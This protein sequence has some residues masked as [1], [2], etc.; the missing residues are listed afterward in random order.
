MKPLLS[1][2]ALTVVCL[3]CLLGLAGCGGGENNASGL[4]EENG[5]LGLQLSPED[6]TSGGMTLI[7]LQE[8][9]DL[10]GDWATGAA[11]TLERQEDGRWQAVEPLL[12]EGTYGWDYV[13]Y[14]IEMVGRTELP[15]EWAWL[16]GELAPGRYRL[17]KEFF[18][19]HS[20]EGYIPHL[21]R[22]EFDLSA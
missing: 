18:D 16:Y 1:A 13:V 2:C 14:S 12:E 22:V 11:F 6:V 20:P 10:D 7:C 21:C 17:S 15:V 3:C 19:L 4:P 5:A 9:G 8:G